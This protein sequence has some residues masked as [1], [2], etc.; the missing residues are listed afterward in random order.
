MNCYP[1]LLL[2]II[3]VS[4]Q[5][6]NDSPER[7]LYTTRVANET[8]DTAMHEIGYSEFIP[9]A[10]KNIRIERLNVI[11]AYAIGEQKIVIGSYASADGYPVPPDSENDYGN[12]LFLLDGKDNIVFRTHGLL[13]TY[14]YNPHFFRNDQND[15]MII[16]CE[17]AVGSY[18]GGD[19]Y[20]LE[21]GRIKYIGVIDIEGSEM[22]QRLL[23]FI[24]M[25]EK[26]GRII[27][28]FDADSLL[29]HPGSENEKIIKN[30][31]VR[32]VYDSN[33]LKIFR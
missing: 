10:V 1:L 6:K 14:I 28:N 26:R 29:L 20:I 19:V 13:D 2:F 27:F 9:D 3:V 22:D 30:E 15:K 32:Y 31:H 18:C 11:H 8:P 21:K 33:G 24:R 5:E 23:S 17:M 25:K 7:H 12:R 4:C 16:I